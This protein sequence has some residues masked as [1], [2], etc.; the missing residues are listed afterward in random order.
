[1]KNLLLTLALLAGGASAQTA[2]QSVTTTTSTPQTSTAPSSEVYPSG[3][4]F[5]QMLDALGALKGV[6][7]RGVGFDDRGYLNLTVADDAAREQAIA[8]VA[9]AGLPTGVLAFGGVPVSGGTQPGTATEA[10]A[11][12]NQTPAAQ[13]PA[14]PQNSSLPTNGAPLAQAHRAELSGPQVVRA[15]EANTWSFNL[16]NTGSTG[17][18]LEHGACDVRFEVVN[19]AGEVVRTDPTNTICTLQLVVTDVA[20]GQTQEVQ[21]IRW[22]GK[23]AAGQP[24]PAGEYTIRAVFRGAGILI[25]AADFRVTVE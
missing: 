16:T 17:I 19:A 4:T 10:P 24:V 9:A 12:G 20:P 21:K 7:L 13:N 23:D 8:Q 1:M 15:G 14:A 3:Y 18:H 25:R 22:E 6:N 5:R 2:A 11:S